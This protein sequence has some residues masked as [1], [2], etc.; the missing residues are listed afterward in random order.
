MVGCDKMTLIRCSNDIFWINLFF[1]FCSRIRL[2]QPIVD[3][4]NTLSSNFSILYW[5]YS[6]QNLPLP[7]FFLVFVLLNCIFFGWMKTQRE[8]ADFFVDFFFAQIFVYWIDWNHKLI[9]FD[10]QIPRSWVHYAV[11]AQKIRRFYC[12]FFRAR[13]FCVCVFFS[14]SSLT[15]SLVFFFLFGCLCVYARPSTIL[16]VV[17]RTLLQVCQRDCGAR[18]D[19]TTELD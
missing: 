12:S 11:T 15:S 16:M 9:Q 7:F 10:N 3:T 14:S 8:H 4:A 13:P 1:F 18:L 2:L 5:N 17:L 19:G 6:W